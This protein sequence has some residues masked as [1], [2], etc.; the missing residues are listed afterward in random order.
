MLE[1]DQDR[2][3]RV[4]PL[5]YRAHASKPGYRLMC[6]ELVRNMRTRYNCKRMLCDDQPRLLYLLSVIF[7]RTAREQL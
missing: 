4:R 2:I 7:T 5:T 1:L 6:F 3:Q